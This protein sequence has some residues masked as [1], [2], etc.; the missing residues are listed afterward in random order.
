MKYSIGIILAIAGA[1]SLWIA[2]Q[3]HSAVKNNKVAAFVL[4]ILTFIFSMKVIAAIL[5]FL[6][7][8]IF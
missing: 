5:F 4:G 1:C 3:V 8:L 6:Y 7:A 2:L